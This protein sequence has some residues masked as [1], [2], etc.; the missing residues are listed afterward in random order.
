MP[1]GDGQDAFES[2]TRALLGSVHVLDDS[3]ARGRGAETTKVALVIN[4][5]TAKLL[6]IT[7]PRSLLLRADEVIR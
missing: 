4:L 7:V 2:G 3:A 1:V 5:K 6:G